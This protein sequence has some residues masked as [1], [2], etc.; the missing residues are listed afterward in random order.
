MRKLAKRAADHYRKPLGTRVVQEL[1]ATWSSIRAFVELSTAS[2][3]A[4]Y[5]RTECCFYKVR[6]QIGRQ[7]TVE[8]EQ[9]FGAIVS[10][11][12]VENTTANGSLCSLRM[13]AIDKTFFRF[14]DLGLAGRQGQRDGQARN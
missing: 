7:S 4:P 9:L 1:T 12:L 8:F 11:Q 13:T 3:A 2:T 14:V 6:R 10:F 5:T